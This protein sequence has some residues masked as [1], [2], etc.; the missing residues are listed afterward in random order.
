MIEM[1]CAITF[2]RKIKKDHHYIS[3]GG[4]QAVNPDNKDL[5][6]DFTLSYGK[7]STK[8]PTDLHYT[9]WKL[10]PDIS[11][12]SNKKPL[13]DEDFMKELLKVTDFKEFFIY[14]G[15]NDDPEINPV[16]IKSLCFYGP[17]T[18]TRN[19]NS[20]LWAL[21]KL[22]GANLLTARHEMLEKINAVLSNR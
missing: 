17:K 19:V 20:E 6:F 7:I 14:T 3:P 15:E 16:S 13:S 21:E 5:R 12:D 4:Y 18:E 8:N 9:A 10:D 11:I 1:H 22:P 2:D